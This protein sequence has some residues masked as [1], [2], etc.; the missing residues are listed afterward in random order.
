MRS[1]L[2]ALPHSRLYP[3]IFCTDFSWS[4]L[5]SLHR[6]VFMSPL[7]IPQC[8]AHGQWAT[9]VWW[10]N[11]RTNCYVCS[12]FPFPPVSAFLLKLFW[13][14]SERCGLMP[15]SLRGQ[16]RLVPKD[17]FPGWTGARQQP[18]T[19]DR[20]VYI[21]KLVSVLNLLVQVRTLLNLK[22]II[23]MRDTFRACNGTYL[24]TSGSA[25]SRIKPDFPKLTG[26]AWWQVLPKRGQGIEGWNWEVKC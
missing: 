24:K 6:F 23:Q 13:K 8:Q 21:W 5:T 20:G 26:S 16:P 25:S 19:A 22:L 11:Q 4:T 1:L 10:M 15:R 14:L 3:A 9:N 2:I 7:E 12:Y 17:N 18:H